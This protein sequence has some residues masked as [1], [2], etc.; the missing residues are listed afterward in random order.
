MF[1]LASRFLQ[2]LETRQCRG[3]DPAFPLVMLERANELVGS[4]SCRAQRVTQGDR[5]IQRRRAVGSCRRPTRRV[6]D[7]TGATG[8]LVVACRELSLSSGGY[9]R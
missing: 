5:L 2:L 4:G 8:V 7:L 3:H 6:T 1:R 9:G